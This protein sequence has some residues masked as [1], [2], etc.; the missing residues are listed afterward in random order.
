MKIT[1]SFLVYS[2]IYVFGF[3]KF[4]KQSF[5][6]SCLSFSVIDICI[7]LSILLVVEFHYKTRL[8][9]A[10]KK[11]H[12]KYIV[13]SGEAIGSDFNFR[14]SSCSCSFDPRTDSPA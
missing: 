4:I 2:V 14:E 3:Y 8:T 10:S 1:I 6:F 9:S 11:F 13:A 5:L 7:V 12:E